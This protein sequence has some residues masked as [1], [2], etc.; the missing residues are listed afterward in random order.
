M[1]RTSGKAPPDKLSAALRRAAQA[2]GEAAFFMGRY[3]Q[4]QP[5]ASADV[6][7]LASLAYLLTFVLEAQPSAVLNAVQLESAAQEIFAEELRLSPARAIVD[8]QAFSL[9]LRTVLGHFRVLARE[10]NRFR[11]RCE[12]VSEQSV[13]TVQALI[14]LYKSDPPPRVPNSWEH[15]QAK[16]PQSG[17]D[18]ANSSETSKPQTKALEAAR[19]TEET[20]QSLAT[21]KRRVVSAAANVAPQQPATSAAASLSAIAA[22]EQNPPGHAIGTAIAFSPPRR[23]LTRHISVASESPDFSKFSPA[24]PDEPPAKDLTLQERMEMRVMDAQR[25][26]KQVPMAVAGLLMDMQLVPR[27]AGFRE[28]GQ[29]A[30][31][32]R[33]KKKSQVNQVKQVSQVPEKPK[34]KPK[35]K[36]KRKREASG[37]SSA[38]EAPAKEIR[39]VN[40]KP[41]A[42]N[43]QTV[44][45]V[46]MH[47]ARAGAYAVRYV[48]GA[49]V[50]QLS[51]KKT[52]VLK[53]K[54]KELCEEACLGLNHGH[55]EFLAQSHA[56]SQYTEAKAKLHVH[57]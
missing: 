26:Q 35:K 44:K 42:K 38:V 40:K 17:P 36:M 20:K 1:G 6:E 9:Q 16:K 29:A 25:A 7:A 10:P 3:A 13:A 34:K 28:E 5:S 52:P 21:E 32:R 41:A 31:V 57:D 18:S 54:A 27:A 47:Y 43:S 50:F 56:Q 55:K 12:G 33:Q 30:A 8:A 37:A 19:V 22:G 4:I 48:G 2:R 39:Q 49:Q 45:A 51:Y 46:T 14:G 24:A 15:V 11:A 23:R 53:T